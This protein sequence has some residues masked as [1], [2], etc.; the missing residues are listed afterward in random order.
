LLLTGISIFIFCCHKKH[1]VNPVTPVFTDGY[2]PGTLFACQVDG[3]PWIYHWAWG[4]PLNCDVDSN[5]FYIEARANPDHDWEEISFSILDS[6]KNLTD[7]TYPLGDANKNDGISS[8]SLIDIFSFDSCL[9]RQID[10]GPNYREPS[11]YGGLTI[12]KLDTFSHL[13]TGTFWF[14]IARLPCDTLK[15]TH[16]FFNVGFGTP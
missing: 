10:S 12:T 13:I 3:Q 8:G 7:T 16:G 11:F 4:V 15:V 14:D 1:F 6:L 9:D 5:F 2:P